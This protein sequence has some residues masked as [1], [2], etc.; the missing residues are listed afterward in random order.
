MEPDQLNR[1]FSLGTGRGESAEPEN[2]EAEPPQPADSTEPS[3]S[4]DFTASLQSSVEQIG[5]WIGPYKLVHM[6][7]EGGMGVVYLAQQEQPIRRQLALKVIKPGM[8]TLSLIH[9]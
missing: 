2:K 4:S 5:Q 7:G 8:D 6:L 1:L 3:N 9:I